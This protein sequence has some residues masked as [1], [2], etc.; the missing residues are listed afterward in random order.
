[1]LEADGHSQKLLSKQITLRIHPNLWERFNQK[2][3]DNAI[4]PATLILRLIDNEMKHTRK[5]AT[6]E[7]RGPRIT[8][9]CVCLTCG[10]K[11]KS[12]KDS[13]KCG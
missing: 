8:D 13:C 10:T 11:L 2:C 12:S 3:I 6:F 5:V 9:Q 1:M 7:V 4:S